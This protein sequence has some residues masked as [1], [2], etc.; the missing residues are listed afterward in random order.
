M[1]VSTIFDLQ[2][3]EKILLLESEATS[4]CVRNPG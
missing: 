1:S 4:T 2:H 3:V